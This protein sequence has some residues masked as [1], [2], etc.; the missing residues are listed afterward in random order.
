MPDNYKEIE[1]KLAFRDEAV[2]EQLLGDRYIMDMHVPGTGRQQLLETVYYDSPSGALQEARLS[3][4][5]RRQGEEWIATVKADGSSAGGLHE[6]SEWSAEVTEPAPDITPLLALPV[7][8]RLAAALGEEKL[9]EIMR[10]RFWRRSLDLQHRAA[11]IELAV[12]CGEILAGGKSGLIREIELELKSGE[13]FAIWEIAEAL[14]RKYELLPEERSKYH[15]GLVL[16]G[17]IL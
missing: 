2:G 17:K 13:V 3:Y 8:E 9:T 7:G 6:R 15:R 5:I 16:A 10:T 11:L 12:D 14:R 4:R 1:L